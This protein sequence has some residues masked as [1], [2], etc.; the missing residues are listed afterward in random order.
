MSWKRPESVLVVIYTRAG[1]CL[2]LRR[3]QPDDFWQSV[4]GS[5]RWDESP[6][7]AARRELK[8]ETG[9]PVDSLQ[10]TGQQYQFPIVPPWKARYAP[11]VETNTETV[12]ALPLQQPIPPR[13]NPEEHLEYRWLTKADA[14][15]LVTSWTNREAIERLVPTS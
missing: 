9:F 13:L 6:E 3:R 2:L 7:Q 1:D 12:F 11:G 14:L 5:L 10:P 15:K 4:T 8:E